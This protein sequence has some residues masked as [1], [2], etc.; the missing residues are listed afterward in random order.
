[1]GI[2]PEKMYGRQAYEK[3]LFCHG[4]CC[5]CGH[6]VQTW[7]LLGEAVAEKTPA[8]TMANKKPMDSS[9]FRFQQMKIAVC[10]F[11]IRNE[12]TVGFWSKL[13]WCYFKRVCWCGRSDSDW[14]GSQSMKDTP[15]Q[16]GMKDEDTNDVS[17][18][19]K[20]RVYQKVNLL[21]HSRTLFLQT[22]KTFSVRKPQFGSTTFWLLQDNFLY[23]FIFLFSIP[24]LYIK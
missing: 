21:F 6:H 13:G 23:S 4:S 22:K 17:Q 12:K 15:A 14:M 19:Q 8:L 2:S 3:M 10:S 7:D 9:S 18:W 11:I 20:G 5:L 16:L 24:L 1:M